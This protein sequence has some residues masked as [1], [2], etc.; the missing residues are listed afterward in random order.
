MASPLQVWE[1][2]DIRNAVARLRAAVPQV[3]D[4]AIAIQQIPAPTF[5]EAARAAYVR[6]RFA[7]LGLHDVQVDVQGNVYGR[8]VGRER[9][10]TLAVTAHL[11]TVFSAETDLTLRR[12]NGHIYGPG[13][14]D[15]S[16]G[17]AGLIALAAQLQ[18][19]LP[20]RDVWAV[21][22]VGEEG[23]GN[24]RGM[25][26]AMRH[27]EETL[28]GVVVLEGGALGTIIHQGIGV[29]RRRLTVETAGG[30]SWS[31][32]G[33]PSA[34][35]ELC[36]IG[37]AIAA[38][39]LPNGAP[40]SFNLGIIEGGT[41]INTIAAR[42]TALLDLRAEEISGLQALVAQVDQIVDAAWRDGVTVE[43]E[44]IGERPSGGI[45]ATHPLVRAAV[46][47]LEAVS[48]HEPT[49]RASST[50]ANVPFA[51]G[52]PAVCIGLTVGNNAH[53]LDEYVE[54]APLGSGL[55]HAL[56]VVVAALEM[57]P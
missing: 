53:R 3:M 38:M 2:R 57:L 46:A 30:H 5:H 48:H 50:D 44:I 9:G 25:W 1:S 19:V 51:L 45:P 43:S 35:H 31:D 52:I 21:A 28:G 4:E 6:Q 33:T 36:R 15:N 34:I 7:E 13:I 32:F 54:L 40:A 12:E 24:L 14:G 37:A 10:P 18:Q 8:V 41:S 27:L 39:E 11:D 42:A 26:A 20:R 47:A 16:L 56:L 55:H 23:L 49:L 17:V 29:Q 22:N